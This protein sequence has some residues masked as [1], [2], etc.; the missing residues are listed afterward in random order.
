MTDAHIKELNDKGFGWVPCIN[1]KHSAGF[2]RRVVNALED[3][4]KY[5]LCWN[6]WVYAMSGDKTEYP[7][8]ID[9]MTDDYDKEIAVDYKHEKFKKDLCAYGLNKENQ[10]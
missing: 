2:V 10:K 8:F 4:D 9:I 6:E 5:I 7:Y 1:C 3:E